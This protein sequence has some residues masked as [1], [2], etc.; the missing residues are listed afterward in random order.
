MLLLCHLKLQTSK[1]STQFQSR[2]RFGKFCRKSSKKIATNNLTT[3]LFSCYWFHIFQQKN[4]NCDY[5]VTDPPSVVV[6]LP[7]SKINHVLWYRVSRRINVVRS[8][9]LCLLLVLLIRHHRW[10]Q[11]GPQRQKWLLWLTL[12][13]TRRLF[14]NPS[15]SP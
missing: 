2:W 13:I 15:F 9:K 12:F 3:L 8:L 14:T 5:D 4:P 10:F 1:Q 11:K 7:H 6:L